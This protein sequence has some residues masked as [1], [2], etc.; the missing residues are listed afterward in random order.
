MRLE[1]ERLILRQWRDEDLDDLAAMSADLEVMEWMGGVLTREEAR[2]FMDRAHASFARHGMGRFA[3]VT[4]ADEAFVGVTGLMPGHE[5]LADVLASFTDMSWVLRR[6]AWGQ[7]YMTEACRAVI[8]DGF[9]RLDL[10]EIT[11]MTAPANLRS[12]A[13]MRRLGMVAEPSLDFDHPLYPDGHRLR[14]SLVHKAR[15]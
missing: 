5:M 3:V 10:P 11:A 13:V 4:K 15:R 7:G 8:A 6:E 14:R 1:T 12:Q 9:G 2:A